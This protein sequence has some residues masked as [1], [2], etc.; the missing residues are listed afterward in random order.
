MKYKFLILV[1]LMCM[2]LHAE[3][4]YSEQYCNSRSD[5]EKNTGLQIIVKIL[6]NDRILEI[7]GTK[8][9]DGNTFSEYKLLM[10]RNSEGSL[11]DSVSVI[12]YDN[13]YAYTTSVTEDAV[14]FKIKSENEPIYRLVFVNSVSNSISMYPVKD[15]FIA[16]I[17]I[18]KTFILYST[19]MDYN[20]IRKIDINTGETS[21]V[22]GYYPNAEI[23]CQAVNGK[24]KFWFI[25]ENRCYIID[26]NE[27]IRSNEILQKTKK[28]EI[29]DLIMK[30][31]VQ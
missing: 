7:L 3:D 22:K 2:F 14:C 9:G 27:A 30:E 15:K 18:G 11:L 1:N 5:S 20:T 31:V 17:C 25:Y 8:K 28:T 29:I 26:G 12:L 16:D 24:E 23:F 19:E 4:I 13:Q 6:I 21:D 10:L